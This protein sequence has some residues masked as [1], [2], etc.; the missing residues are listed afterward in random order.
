MIAGPLVQQRCLH[1]IAVL[2]TLVEVLHVI[3]HVNE[4]TE[5]RLIYI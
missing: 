1:T 3:Q 4:V 2:Q 5:L